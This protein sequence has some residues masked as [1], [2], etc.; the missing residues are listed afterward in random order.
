L[1]L[2]VKE[3][4]MSEPSRKQQNEFERQLR[5]QGL[6]PVKLWLPDTHSPKFMA[7]YQRQAKTIAEHDPAGDE[8]MEWLDKVRDWPLD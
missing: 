1:L 4:A 7:E 2:A 8:A 6:R 5:A 3:P